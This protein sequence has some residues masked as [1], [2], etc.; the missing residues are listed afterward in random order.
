MSRVWVVYLNFLILLNSFFYLSQHSYAGLT[1][2]HQRSAAGE[3]SRSVESASKVESF[4]KKVVSDLVGAVCKD[5]SKACDRTQLSLSSGQI[6]KTKMI[7]DEINKKLMP[8]KMTENEEFMFSRALILAQK[9]GLGCQRSKSSGCFSLS[10][11][12]DTVWDEGAFWTVVGPGG[13]EGVNDFQ[14]R[15]AIDYKMGQIQI[16]RKLEDSEYL[17]YGVDLCSCEVRSFSSLGYSKSTPS[18]RHQEGWEYLLQQEEQQEQDPKLLRTSQL[19]SQLHE[20]GKLTVATLGFA[21]GWLGKGSEYQSKVMKSIRVL[22]QL[23]LKQGKDGVGGVITGG[24]KGEGDNVYGVT[25]TGHEVANI[26]GYRSIVVTPKAGLADT[27]E[28][29]DSRSVVGHLWGDDSKALVAATDIALV[30]YRG[31]THKEKKGKMGRW[32]EIEIAHLKQQGVPYIAIDIDDE[33]PEIAEYIKKEVKTIAQRI[34]Y[35][36]VEVEDSQSHDYQIGSDEVFYDESADVFSKDHPDSPTKNG[37]SKPI[38]RRRTRVESDTQ[39]DLK[40]SRWI[41]NPKSR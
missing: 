15:I 26:D 20:S 9:H 5:V 19:V 18:E 6:A 28:N 13:C 32:T 11:E 41:R 16:G 3:C 29:P 38:F 33:V 40:S 10:L 36:S 23:F 39:F 37:S 12:G 17:R 1:V 24:Y 22:N 25:R 27:H 4:A 8:Q 21:R 30:F 2:R 34:P 14:S 35:Y 7:I 31:Q